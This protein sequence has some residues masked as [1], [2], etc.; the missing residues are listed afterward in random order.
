MKEALQAADAE[1]GEENDDPSTPKMVYDSKSGK[2]V[3][4]P[5]EKARLD[6]L[7]KEK[8]AVADQERKERV[9]KL[10]VN[11]EKKLAIFTEGVESSGMGRPE[12]VARAEREVGGSFKVRLFLFSFNFKLHLMADGFANQTDYMHA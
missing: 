6:K 1:T 10:V 5:E 3:V 11:L 4:P 7:K 9:D 2:M 12:D 8:D